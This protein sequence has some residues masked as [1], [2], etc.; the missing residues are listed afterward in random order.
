VLWQV[1]FVRFIHSGAADPGD[2]LHSPAEGPFPG[3]GWQESGRVTS[4]SLSKGSCLEMQLLR[5][6]H[7]ACFC[8]KLTFFCKKQTNKKTHKA[9]AHVLW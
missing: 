6:D 4:S 9:L 1:D 7:T 2:L 5:G 3:A 8:G